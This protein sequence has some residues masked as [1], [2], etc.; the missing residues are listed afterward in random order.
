MPFNNFFINF[1]QIYLKIHLLN[2]VQIKKK[3]YKIKIKK[4]QSLS[5]GEEKKERQ[6]GRGRYENILE[7][8]KQK[9]A[10]YRKIIK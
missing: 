1:L 2:I 7:D 6:Y 3:D 8:G 10:E 9:L 4:Y 5:K